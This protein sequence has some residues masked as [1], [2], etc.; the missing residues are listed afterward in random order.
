MLSQFNTSPINIE[1]LVTSVELGVGRM[2]TV[3]HVRY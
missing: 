2:N 3:L 1:P